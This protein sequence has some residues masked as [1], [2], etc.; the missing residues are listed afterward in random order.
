MITIPILR[1]VNEFRV[2]LPYEFSH[3]E[4]QQIISDFIVGVAPAFGWKRAGE[5]KPVAAVT[6]KSTL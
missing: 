1:E 2:E 4:Y 6:D 5:T 3:Q